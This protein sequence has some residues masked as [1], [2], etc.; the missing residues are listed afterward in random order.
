VS[1]FCWPAQLRSRRE[2][3][4]RNAARDCGSCSYKTIEPSAAMTDCSVMIEQVASEV[5]RRTPG[6]RTTLWARLCS[7]ERAL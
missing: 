4:S 6:R 7:V 5:E 2:R 3:L 1:Y